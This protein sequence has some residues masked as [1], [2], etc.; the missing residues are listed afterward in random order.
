MVNYAQF[1]AGTPLQWTIGHTAPRGLHTMTIGIWGLG[2]VARRFIPM[3]ASFEP[4]AILVLSD[5]L[6]DAMAD[7]LGVHR[8]DFDDLFERSD[9]VHLLEG[10]TPQSR[11]RVGARHLAAM[12]FG[13][14]LI[15]AGRAA[16]VQE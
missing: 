13:A 11:G 4:R 10:L 2:A 7:N 6:D 16:L 1:G 8:V 15:N 3:L 14:T 5:H 9:V 12:P